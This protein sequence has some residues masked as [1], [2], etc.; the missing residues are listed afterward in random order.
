MALKKQQPAVQ[1]FGVGGQYLRSA[2]M[3]TL[4]DTS[5]IA[6]MGL[7]EARINCG[8]SSTPSSADKHSEHSRRIFLFS[9]TF[10]NSIYGSRRLP[11]KV[12]VRVFYYISPQVWVRRKRRVYTIAK[13]LIA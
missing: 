11:N 6:G 1:V 8:R 10:L 12:G 4:V 2:G 3:Q 7:F 13:R 9:S 5:T